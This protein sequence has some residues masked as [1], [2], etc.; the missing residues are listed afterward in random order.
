MNQVI[1]DKVYV[2]TME[3]TIKRFKD[4][5]GNYWYDYRDLC[6]EVLI[7][8]RERN[9]IFYNWVNEDER[10]EAS[11]EGNR[12]LV[13]YVSAEGFKR[14]IERNYQRGMWIYNDLVNSEFKESEYKNLNNK[15]KDLSNMIDNNGNVTDIV[16]TVNNIYQ[17]KEYKDLLYQFNP[18]LDR[19]KDMLAEMIRYDLYMDEDY[20]EVKM[21]KKKDNGEEREILY[22]KYKQNNAPST[23]PSWIREVIK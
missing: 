14:I 17:D 15:L 6:G 16:N 2:K 9:Y 11:L 4:E 19:E 7:P 3:R 1:L 21:T 22:K 13:K 12:S 18:C 23:C 20:S 5:F 8:D 10:C